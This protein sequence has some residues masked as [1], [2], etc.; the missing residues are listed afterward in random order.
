[1]AKT[2]PNPE[3]RDSIIKNADDL[4]S[5]G[6]TKGR[7]I[8]LD[9]I[10]AALKAADPYENTKRMLRVQDGKLIVGHPEFSRPKG[11]K[12][13]VFD[14]SKVGNIYLV[15]GGKAAQNMAKGVE[16]VLGDLITDGH[17]ATKKGDRIKLKRV[18]V[19]L[20]G[21]PM[22]DEDSV[23]AGRRVYEIERQAKKGDIV[24][25]CI[26]GGATA[27]LA[28][29]VPG[30]S[31]EDL[32]K[33]YRLLYFQ[34]GA[35]MPE[36]NAVRNHLALV[37]LKH[38]RNVGDATLVQILTDEVPLDLRVHLYSDQ[39]I[40]DGHQAAIDI[41]KQYGC[42]EEA[43]ASV[44]EFL[45]RRDP[46]YGPVSPEETAG[47]PQYYYRV[48]GPEY[49]LEAAK[50]RAEELGLNATVLVSSLSDV[51]ARPIGEMFGYLTQ[52]A[53]VLG[54]PVRPPC[55]FLCGGEL[56]VT[57]GD[58]QGVGG[59]AQEFVLAAAPRI[60]GSE[61]IVIAA[62]GT[63]GSDGPTDV[64]GGI[65]DGYTMSRVAECGIN[66]REELKRHNSNPVLSTLGDTIYTGVTGTNVRDILVGYVGGMRAAPNGTHQMSA[67]SKGGAQ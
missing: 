47:K 7:R 37:N 67:S 62:A 24:F 8:V 58:E 29:P 49:M 18:G 33:V 16:D 36:A 17:V 60:A 2:P 13:V 10:E 55:V 5:R 34:K 54:R 26:S 6:N 61:N 50:K 64:D 57:V 65:V 35:S 52:E 53:E 31:L 48:M 30:I 32:R 51:E 9:I 21:H 28:Y 20:A 4:A 46:Q 11:Q 42:W 43:P 3:K 56:I 15:G 22:P 40:R 45:N 12:P 25:A 41:L 39:A 19:T 38:A 44:R 1:M 14:L 27:L 66:L 23:A 59:R 63:D